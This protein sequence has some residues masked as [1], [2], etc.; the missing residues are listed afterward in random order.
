MYVTGDGFDCG[1][2]IPVEITG[3]QGYDLVGVPVVD[4]DGKGDH[5]EPGYSAGSSVDSE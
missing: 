3:A 4:E 2:M 1:D 5:C